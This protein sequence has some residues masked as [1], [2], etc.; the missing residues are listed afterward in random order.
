MM[1]ERCFVSG[2][3]HNFKKCCKCG[4]EK[5]LFE[6]SDGTVEHLANCDCDVTAI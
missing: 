3:W 2:K 1:V 5:V 6:R 4:R